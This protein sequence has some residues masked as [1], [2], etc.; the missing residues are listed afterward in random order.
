MLLSIRP[1]PRF[2]V[3]Y[4]PRGESS[5]SSLLTGGPVMNVR[6]VNALLHS[7]ILAL[8]STPKVL[9]QN[10]SRQPRRS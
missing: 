5:D 1:Y 10:V 2:P 3:V 4:C 8:L 9:V 7:F 6:L